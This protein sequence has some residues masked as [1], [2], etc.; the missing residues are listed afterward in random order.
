MAGAAAAKNNAP[1]PTGDDLIAR[2]VAHQILTY[3]Y[4]TLWDDVDFRLTDGTVHIFG[5]VTQPFKKSA[6]G[7]LIG[8]VPGVTTVDNELKVAPLSAFD[9]RIRQQVADA[10]YRDPALSRYRL[11]AIPSI[12][13]I[14][15]S[16][17]VTLEGVVNTEMEKEVAGIRANSSMSFGSVTNNLRVEQPTPKR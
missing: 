16:G 10:I 12:H 3:P 2:N 11:Q 13:V 6:L 17:H 8:K 9:D 15:D 5:E 14:V 1:P 7:S 4:Y